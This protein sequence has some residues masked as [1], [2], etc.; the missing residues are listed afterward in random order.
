[1]QVDGGVFHLCER[2]GL[3]VVGIADVLAM[4][5][6]LTKSILECIFG[7]LI[8]IEQTTGIAAQALL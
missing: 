7:I 1:M 2:H 4:R 8:V 3:R 5:P 6:E